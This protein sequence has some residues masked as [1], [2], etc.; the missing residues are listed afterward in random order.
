MSVK[1][2]IADDHHIVRR[3]LQS[4]LKLDPDIVVVGEA[5]NGQE[6][7]E[8]CRELDPDVVIMDVMMPV[9]DGLKATSFIKSEMPRIRIIILTSLADPGSVSKA[10]L[11]GADDYLVKVKDNSKLFASIK[12]LE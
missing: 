7:I 3:G 4:Y 1:V 12:G 5:I 10:L 9:M 6:A 2:I 8:K 11:A